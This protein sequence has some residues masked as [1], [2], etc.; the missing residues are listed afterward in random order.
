MYPIATFSIP[1]I[2][3]IRWI[4]SSGSRGSHKFTKTNVLGPNYIEKLFHQVL[5]H[6]V[7]S[8]MNSRRW[9]RCY[10]LAVGIWLTR[11]YIDNWKLICAKR[12][13]VDILVSLE[14][15]K[16]VEGRFRYFPPIWSTLTVIWRYHRFKP[17]WYLI[18]PKTNKLVFESVGAPT[19]LVHVTIWIIETKYF[20]A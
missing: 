9:R 18:G 10:R 12:S 17:I 6:S 1:V 15:S 20:L 4:R 16:L 2:V 8:E 13:Q 11:D 19:N 14:P 5:S 7:Q 3:G